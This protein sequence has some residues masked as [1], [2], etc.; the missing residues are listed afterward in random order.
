MASVE[1]VVE[2]AAAEVVADIAL[3][4][5]V[6]TVVAQAGDGVESDAL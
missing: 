4:V 3:S 1:A 5:W 6:T 2:A